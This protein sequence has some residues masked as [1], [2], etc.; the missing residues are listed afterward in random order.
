MSSSSSLPFVVSRLQRPGGRVDSAPRPVSVS[1]KP[2]NADSML[3]VDYDASMLMKHGCAE[4]DDCHGH[5]PMSQAGTALLPGFCV[6]AD[7]DMKDERARATEEA[8]VGAISPHSYGTRIRATMMGKSGLMRSGIASCRPTTSMRGV[9]TCNW[10]SDPHVVMIPRS[11]MRRAKIPYRRTGESDCSSPY[12]A[13]RPAKDGDRA[14]L[15]RCPIVTDSSVQPITIAAWDN[16][17][18]GVNP[19]MCKPLNLDFDGDE[20][21]VIIV[22]SPEASSEIDRLIRS[23]RLQALTRFVPCAGEGDPMAATTVCLDDLKTANFDGGLYK[24]ANCKE[25]SRQG[26]CKKIESGWKTEYSDLRSSW[27]SAVANMTMSHLSVSMGYTLARQL[28]IASMTVEERDGAYYAPWSEAPGIRVPRSLEPCDE[29][30]RETGYPA[31]RLASRLAG[32]IMQ[33][34]LDAAKGRGGRSQAAG[35]AL[36]LF[37]GS[38]PCQTIAKTEHGLELL[39]VE[40]PERLGT[41]PQSVVASTHPR[42]LKYAKAQGLLHRYC[43]AMISMCCSM[44]GDSP[45]DAELS[46]LTAL[47][48]SAFWSAGSLKVTDTSPVHFLTSTPVDRL[49]ASICDDI[50]AMEGD[51]SDSVPIAV[52]SPYPAL[53]TGNLSALLHLSV[54]IAGDSEF[55]A[56]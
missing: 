6:A 14:V 21:H 11:W 13:F 49:T 55:T 10:D 24:A 15:L 4:H 1:M 17:S 48:T 33:S 2:L 7:L 56:Q 3:F 18:I 27:S 41:K 52:V 34:Y 19:E 38:W 37:T 12:Y 29:V 25:T 44:S 28:K 42:A 47:V 35:L 23:S 45:T 54:G 5:L 8:S 50:R 26:M 22:S 43:A 40:E 39:S 16:A 51:H 46:A 9:A 32:G 20:V 53:S 36:S 31:A 30:R